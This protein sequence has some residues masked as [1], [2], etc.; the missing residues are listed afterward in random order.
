MSLSL[1]RNLNQMFSDSLDDTT[2]TSSPIFDKLPDLIMRWSRNNI[3]CGRGKW[4]LKLTHRAVAW[5]AWQAD[6]GGYLNRSCICWYLSLYFRHVPFSSVV[7]FHPS[8][9]HSGR[10]VR[11]CLY[12]QNHSRF[13]SQPADKLYNHLRLFHQRLSLRKFEPSATDMVIFDR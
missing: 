13:E 2:W 3:N 5:C 9:S 1:Y 8:M 10:H 11:R 12:M 4:M 7:V 6:R